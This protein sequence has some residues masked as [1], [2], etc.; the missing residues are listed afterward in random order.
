MFREM[1]RSKQALSREEIDTILKNATSGVLALSGD[2]GYPYAVPLSFY[3]DGER[4]IFHCAK[5]GHKMDALRHCGKASFCVIAQDDVLP[6]KF[7]TCYR[8]VIAFGRIRE[9]SD[10]REMREMIRLIAKK[11]S[12]TESAESTEAEID[13]EWAALSML[14]LE[15]EHITGNEAIELKRARR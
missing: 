14:V 3:Y 8:S 7:T 6:E 12:P 13:R 4:L 5:T 9:M 10:E 11:Y 2:N 15:I 1:R